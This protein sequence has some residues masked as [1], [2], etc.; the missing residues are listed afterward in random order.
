MHP[1]IA[2]DFNRLLPRAWMGRPGVLVR[3]AG[4]TPLPRVRMARGSASGLSLIVLL[5]PRVADA[6]MHTKR[7]VASIGLF[8]YAWMRADPSHARRRLPSRRVRADGLGDRH[9]T[10]DL[11]ALLHPT[12]G[13]SIHDEVRGMGGRALRVRGCSLG[14]HD[15]GSRIRS[16][17]DRGC[18]SRGDRVHR[19]SSFS[20]GVWMCG[21]STR[22]SR[23][24]WLAFLGCVDV[25]RPILSRCFPPI[26]RA[27][28]C[29]C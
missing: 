15:G 10:C 1:P 16:C 13:C 14:V 20:M 17:P 27:R 25:R 21:S 9:P 11:L 29:P 12:G 23:A 19:M 28:G 8:T 22:A 7:C 6:P 18:A 4:C 26:L 3:R 2:A 5:S 24:V